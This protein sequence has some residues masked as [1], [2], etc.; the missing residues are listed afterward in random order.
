MVDTPVGTVTAVTVALFLAAAALLSLVPALQA[1]F[2]STTGTVRRK[3]AAG[4]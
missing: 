4:A 2:Y 3:Q 1:A